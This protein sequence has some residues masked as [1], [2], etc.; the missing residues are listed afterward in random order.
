MSLSLAVSRRVSSLVLL[1]LVAVL[2]AA[3][4][5]HAAPLDLAS[6]SGAQAEQMLK[7]GTITSVQLTQAYLDRIDALNKQGP[8]LNAVTQL[9]ADALQEAAD[10]DRE[11][12]DGIDLGPAMGLPIVL[13]DIIDAK[14]EYTSAGNWSLRDS[15]PA[16]DSGVA[17]YLRQHGVVILG[18]VGLSEFANFFGGQP[19]GFS[20]L[21]GQVL[22]A[23]DADATPSG[24]SSG[25][26]AAIQSSMSSLGIGTETS[27]SII[28]PSQAEG[29]V[30]L[31]PTVGLVP[32][33]GIAPIIASQ[34]TAGPMERT[35]SDAA[36]T[37]QS[38]TGD[39]PAIEAEADQ[40]YKDVF[41][42][43][44]LA[45]GILP[46]RPSP[47]PNYTSALTTDF[48]QGKRIGYTF[49]APSSCA[50]AQTVANNIAFCA[51]QAAGA[52]M[53]P[54]TQGTAPS[55]CSTATPAT[56]AN[57]YRTTSSGGAVTYST[58]YPGIQNVEVHKTIDG[59]YAHLGPDAPI[60]S[61]ADETTDNNAHPTLAEKFGNYQHWINFQTPYTGT[62]LDTFR[63]DL[64]HNKALIHGFIDAMFNRGTPSDS[65]DDVIAV[66][67]T[68]SSDP[69]AGYPQITVPMGYSATQRRPINASL[70]GTPYT[71][72]TLLGAGYVL[73]QATKLRQT[74]E[75][76]NPSMYRCAKL[77]VAP[78][79]ASRGGCNPS[80]DTASAAAG[81]TDTP[82]LGFKL[83]DATIA[84]LQSR[85][86][87]GTLTS[88]A[89]TK[90]YLN[91][92]ALT[93]AEGPGLQAVRALDAD[94]LT[95]AQAADDARAA[96][97]S[98]P[99]L[100]IPVLL[101][102]SYDVAGMKTSAG[103]I[104]LQSNTPDADS[105]VVTKLKHAGAVIL[106]KT[107][108]TEL[109]NVLDG[110]IVQGYSSLGGQV[111][112]SYDTDKTPAGSSAGSASALSSGLA[113]AT[114]GL[115]TSQNGLNTGGTTDATQFAADAVL[116]ASVMGVDALKPTVGRISRVGVLGVAKAQDS[117]T[118]MAKSITGLAQEMNVL[119]GI[120]GSDTE[121]VASG[122]T[123]ADYTSGLA[124]SLTGHSIGVLPTTTA[125]NTLTVTNTPGYNDAITAL[126]AAGGTA[127][128][129]TISTTTGSQPTTPASILAREFK[130]DLNAY[131]AT[132]HS[133]ASGSLS[134]VVNYLTSHPTEGLKY[135]TTGT[136]SGSGNV[137]NTST[138]QLPSALCTALN[139]PDVSSSG[140]PT[141]VSTYSSD[142]STGRTNYQTYLNTQ[143]ASVDA[144][145]VPASSVLVGYA[146]RAGYPVLE[147][148]SGYQFGFT[149]N[150]SFGQVGFSPTHDPFG[151]ALIGAAN[152]E[153][154]LL[155]DAY[156]IEQKLNTQTAQSITQNTTEGNLVYTDA[157]VA[158]SVYNPAMFR[159]VPGSVYFDPY[160]CH[161][162]DL[163]YVSPVTAPVQPGS[164]SSSGSGGSTPGA[165]TGSAPLGSLAP[166]VDAVQS[167]ELKR[168]L[169][170]VVTHKT[171]KVKV[172][173]TF[174]EPGRVTYHLELSFY[175]HAKS[176]SKKL[177]H[178]YILLASASKTIT[179][180]SSPIVPITLSRT[181][182]REM[183]R[184]PKAAL[185]LRT[186]F[187]SKLTGKTMVTTRPYK[188]G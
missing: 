116:P 171:A 150:T 178:K 104:A 8:A 68:V 22:N 14:G 155:D 123:P 66:L 143:L 169:K 185:V 15:F 97:R 11:R 140:S 126:T 154:T 37:L 87:A 64:A 139:A 111:L 167:V 55:D 177:V 36:I 43:D 93:N 91:R 101:D 181:A 173:D 44:Y 102:D 168:P 124:A 54:V 120:D 78:P 19:S 51:L 151:V 76:L 117:P 70:F 59:Y 162:G 23:V 130:R 13:K 12:A 31:R 45:Q 33:Y 35:V 98:G 106:G 26:G 112:D 20:D 114:I 75:A 166:F 17:A 4:P 10:S 110:N 89:L 105:A 73:E 144:L 30:G 128:T 63:S 57:C 7:G 149:N 18:K 170:T 179:K 175:E 148:Q 135:S 9:N 107:N 119:A 136:G 81:T 94:A 41:G 127:T 48:V 188:R 80:Y 56:P 172:G 153:Q 121:Q 147:M 88:V 77:A 90:A 2:F 161:P 182:R 184:H 118:P 132:G 142:L 49:T 84:D 27:G 115:Q 138:G 24:S 46:A 50:A 53:V 25:T 92:I 99:M 152:S 1:S 122:S 34:D 146:D 74:A 129:K 38:I 6:L 28:S 47:T 103:S 62:A 133:G 3:P 186:I 60:K 61:M 156:A 163:R 72:R 29:I 141:D 39:D 32:G 85:M 5:S 58:G 145:L 134:D 100:G 16:E 160:N 176:S 79:F 108:I 131:L 113:A 83:E 159:C 165:G 137:C 65:S 40:E 183:K 109:N 187:V 95:E 86:A 69:Q 96:G 52:T 125:A 71:E 67:G 21:T 180:A 42:S 158:P 82:D 164:G 157:H 174:V